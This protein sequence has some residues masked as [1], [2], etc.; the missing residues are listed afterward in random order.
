MN[1]VYLRC[2]SEYNS[3]VVLIE[4]GSAILE[5]YVLLARGAPRLGWG[6]LPDDIV[7][8]KKYVVSDVLRVEGR[9][10]AYGAA[11]HP[12]HVLVD[13]V[14]AHGAPLQE[15]V[16]DHTIYHAFPR[17]RLRRSPQ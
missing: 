11:E 4:C 13:E 8:Y 15:L 16:A 5:E 9:V 10:L 12:P 2:K 1:I 14:R 7:V 17:P 6:S 3:Q